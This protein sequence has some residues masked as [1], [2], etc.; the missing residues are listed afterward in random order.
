MIVRPLNLP[1]WTETALSLLCSKPLRGVLRMVLACSAMTYGV[2]ANAQMPPDGHLP[3]C[4]ANEVT[5]QVCLS[6]VTAP[7]GSMIC[8]PDGMKT[9]CLPDVS[10]PGENDIPNVFQ[11]RRD[12][13]ECL[14]NTPMKLINT[15]P[16]TIDQ[17]GGCWKWKRNYTCSTENTEN[18]CQE[19]EDDDNCSVY[20]RRCL[21][22]AGT[23]GCT[24]WEMEYRCITKPGRTDQI[25]FCGDTEICIGGVCWDTSYP[26]DQ[27][28]AQVITDLETAR[29]IGA[30]A[31]DALDMF[32]GVPSYCRS[33]RAAGLKNCCTTDTSAR[34]NNAVM[35]EFVKGAG[36]FAGE[37]GSKYVFDTLYGDTANWLAS[38]WSAAIGGNGGQG[39]LDS[40][41]NPS[42]GMYGFSIG[43]TGSFLGTAGYS[44][45]A[46]GPYPIYFNPY[47]FAFAVAMHVIM[48]SMSCSE[49]E[50][51]LAMRRG[52]GLCSDKIGDW[53]SKE[54]L[55]VCITRKRSYCCYNSKLAKIINV[56]G[57]AQLGMSWGDE[58]SPSCDGFNAAQLKS[59]DFSAI[60]FSEFIGDVME[61]VDMTQIVNDL[62]DTQS[63]EFKDN[64][65]QKACENSWAALQ[66]Q[67]LSQSALPE[68][69]L[70][71]I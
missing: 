40:I 46:V 32:K 22:T 55:G 24:Q 1:A 71:L 11:C 29:E 61:A 8:A 20:G 7:D 3:P 41:S 19:F 39:I 47:A 18:T 38:G 13:E 68:E 4:Q 42:F 57:R 56:Q 67:G 53:C 9:I 70:G 28:F 50:A 64:A 30:Y 5:D 69:C 31:P 10:V 48:Q 58:E 14:D 23:F 44:I 45:G 66:A 54:V 62:T 59:L 2:A 27:D 49:E 25:E 36:S 37:V 21:N 26:P 33:K 6:Y 35:G 51:I 52:A 16:V 15:V 17:V 60:D 12:A 34:S 43:G 65:L 63:G